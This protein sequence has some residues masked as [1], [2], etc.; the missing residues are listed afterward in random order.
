VQFLSLGLYVPRWMR[1]DYPN[2][3]EVGRLGYENFDPETWKNN[4]PNPAF[5]QRTPGD[6]FWAAKKVMAFH[7]DEIGALV[8]TGKFSDPRATDWITK[9]LIERRNRIGRAFFDDVL[10]LDNFAVRGGR[11]MYEDL[12]VKYGFRGARN[13]S[14]Q[15]FEFDN[16]TGARK[17]LPANSFDVPESAVQ[18]IG[19][20]IGG[21]DPAK[22]VTVYLRSD[23]VIGVDR[24]W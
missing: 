7:D 1:A 10:P 14:I 13:Y 8:E 15:W 17:P 12:A 20:R 3:P 16:G 21:D 9:C 11:L 24:T 19:A 22:T 18:Y 23:E 6:T 4:Y 2:I 5:D